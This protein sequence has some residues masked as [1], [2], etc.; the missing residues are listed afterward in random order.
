ME[1]MLTLKIDF[2]SNCVRVIIFQLWK[3]PN[4][5]IDLIDGEKYST[6]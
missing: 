2:I 1:I 5:Y 4:N 6:M 3:F